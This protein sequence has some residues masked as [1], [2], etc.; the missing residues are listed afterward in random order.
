MFINCSSEQ[1]WLAQRINYLTASDA[2]NY[3]GYNPYDPNGKLHLWEEKVGLRKRAD[4]GSKPAVQFGKRAEDHIRALFLLQHPEYTLQYDQYGLYVSDEHPFMAATLDGLLLNNENA[5]HEILEIKTATVHDGKALLDWERGRIPLNY[6]CQI[7]HQ[8]ECVKWAC[9]IWVVALVRMEWNE[10][11]AA[12]LMHHFDVRDEEFIEDRR[13]ITKAAADMW[14]LI[15]AR[16][17]PFT[18]IVL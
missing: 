6:W 10:N 5:Q 3:T 13:E 16:K 17:R 18:N 4:I 7:L 14:Q 9:G 12:F 1:E 8:S 11:E 2:G 15:K